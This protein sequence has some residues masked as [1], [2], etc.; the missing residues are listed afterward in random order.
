MLGIDMSRLVTGAESG[1]SNAD[2]WTRDGY[3]LSM[4]GKRTLGDLNFN[5][6]R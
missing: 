3:C 4:N 2:E 6:A 1:V 5:N